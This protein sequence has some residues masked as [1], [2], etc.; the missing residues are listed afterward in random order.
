L[1]FRNSSRTR[2]IINCRAL[3]VGMFTF[4]DRRR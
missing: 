4:A 2:L 3:W 1:F